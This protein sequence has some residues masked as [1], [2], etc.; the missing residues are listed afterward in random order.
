MPIQGLPPED[1]KSLLQKQC[2]WVVKSNDLVQKSRFDLTAQ[3]NKLLLYLISQIK[4]QDKGD[5]VYSLR[6]SEFCQVCGIDYDGGKNLRD[7]KKA[8]K[9]LADK[10]VWV[11]QADG[12][13]ILLRWLDRVKLN[14][15]TGYFDVTFH[16]DMLPYLYELRTCYTQYTLDVV[17]PM[18]RFASMRL[19][20]LLQSYAYSRKNRTL[21]FS[22]HELYTRLGVRADV[23]W[24]D[25]RRN[26]FQPA[27][28]EI[29][30]YTDI[31]VSYATSSKPGSRAVDYITFDL[32]LAD[33]L[34]LQAR[35]AKRRNKLQK[36]ALPG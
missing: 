10:S 9:S 14:A 22:T 16:K 26:T 17:L 33:D 29:N 23:R 24:P 11:V 3:Q 27:I 19:Y 35:R 8:I 7:A 21:T 5:E 30:T 36:N 28:E 15:A 2:H 1:N 6:P 32:L 18:S 34:T 13:E 20:E 4:P 12:S 31:T 25:F